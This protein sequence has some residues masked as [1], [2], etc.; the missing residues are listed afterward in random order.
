MSASAELREDE[1]ERLDSARNTLFA[2]VSGEDRRA[3]LSSE[4]FR[5]KPSR[6]VVKFGSSL[7]VIALAWTAALVVG[8][9]LVTVGAM[10]VS[11]LMY[12]H[13]VE[14]QHECLHEHAFNSRRL[15]RVFG[16]FCGVFMFSSFWHYKHD[17]LRH[18]AFL[19]TPRNME[20]FNYQFRNLDRWFGLG[21][22]LAAVHPGRYW[23]TCKDIMRSVSGRPIPGVTRELDRKKIQSEYRFLALFIVAATAYSLIAWDPFLLL[24]WLVPTLLVAEP[25]HYLIEMPEHFGLNTQ[26]DPNVLTNTR[27]IKA[28]RFAQW[29]TNFNNLHTAHHYHQGVPMARAQA[30]HATIDNRVVPVDR[31]YWAFYWRVIRGEIKYQGADQTCMTR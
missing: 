24:M 17:H 20:F 3:K 28:S 8:G 13:L 19:G 9:W 4:Y 23:T 16:F 15:N 26:S 27:T 31:S 12:A 22:V 30:L 21:F 2:P 1:V 10:V 14:L 25:T 5:K 18:H 11:G 6:F 7:V 29:F